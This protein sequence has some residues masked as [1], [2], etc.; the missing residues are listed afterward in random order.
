M[1]VRPRMNPS[2]VEVFEVR[3]TDG[4]G[5]RKGRT[6]SFESDAIEFDREIKRMKQ[7]GADL[8]AE[9][10]RRKTTIRDIVG[11]WL[12]V[13]EPKL[14]P[15]PAVMYARQIEKRILPAFGERR[16][17]EITVMDV[18]KW[19]AERM[20]AGDGAATVRYAAAVLSKLLTIA[21]KDGIVSANVAILADK[22][23]AQPER[24]PLLITVEQVELMRWYMLKRGWID[25][26]LLLELLAYVGLRPES[27]AITARWGQRRERS[28]VVRSGKTGTRTIPLLEPVLDSLAL[29]LEAV[30]DTAD[31]LIVPAPGGKRAWTHTDWRNWR[32]RKFAPAAAFAELR[33]DARPRD[34]RGSFASLLIH[35][36]HNIV[37]VATWMGHS[38]EVAL[39]HYLH[40][41]S[42]APSDRIAPAEAILA[43][44]KKLQ[45]KPITDAFL[46]HTPTPSKE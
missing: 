10:R 1:S 21:V 20:A 25:D 4:S 15:G 32:Q 22:P 3:Y 42:D 27:E 37:E 30:P 35:G 29:M 36:G 33:A 39:R 14:Q 46:T 43:A 28:L 16:V 24:T 19:I 41:L 13:H 26:V 7:L 44:R 6:F 18:E 11:V 9:D 12:E 23:T 8:V 45:D 5:K 17:R 2:G 38:P 40:I 31:D 34:L